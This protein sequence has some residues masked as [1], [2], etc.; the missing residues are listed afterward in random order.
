MIKSYE[1][2]TNEEEAQLNTQLKVYVFNKQVSG[3][4]YM[5]EHFYYE[6]KTEIQKVDSQKQELNITKVIHKKIPLKLG[7]SQ[8]KIHNMILDGT[9]N[10]RLFVI[11]QK[12]KEEKLIKKCSLLEV[13]ELDLSQ[14]DDFTSSPVKHFFYKEGNYV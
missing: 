13:D 14:C 9:N 12:E 4:D 7:D 11:G 1:E 5:N 10:F 8:I 3:Q 6:F 2:S